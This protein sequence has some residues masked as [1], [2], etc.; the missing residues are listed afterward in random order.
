MKEFFKVLFTNAT[1]LTIVSGVLVYVFCQIFMDYIVEPKREYKKLKQKILYSV[2]MYRCYYIS[3]YNVFDEKRNARSK[4]E[5][6]KA[7]KEMRKIGSELS[8]Y[9]GI[10][11]KKDLE[12]EKN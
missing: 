3:P 4:E 2:D 5:Y 6:D 8:S 9:I 7:S 12:R 11:W 10:I 1:F